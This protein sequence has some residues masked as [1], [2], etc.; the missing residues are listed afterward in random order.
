MPEVPRGDTHVLQVGAGGS[1][2]RVAETALLLRQPAT[3]V[4]MLEPAMRQRLDAAIDG[5]YVAIHADSMAQAL[6]RA[7]RDPSVRALLI[8]PCA[9]RVEQE[10]ALG[11]LALRC[12]GVMA[13]AIV[14]DRDPV[15]RERLLH[16]G[17]Q[18]VRR[19]VDV[20]ERD[21]WTRLRQL[22]GQT[23]SDT[24]TTILGQIIRTV[25]E[26]T[27]GTHAFFDVVVRL[28]PTVRS[29]KA[30][31]KTLRMQPT[32]LMSRFARAGL[33]S[34]KCYLV[35]IRLAYAA[36][37]LEPRT[38]T[39]SDVAYRLQFACPQSFGRHVRA[40]LGITAREF[41]SR[42]SLAVALDRLLDCLVI[43]FRAQLR[44]F[45]PLKPGRI[46]GRAPG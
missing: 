44:E 8:S 34:P 46:A 38:V 33:P 9:L 32:T 31:A 20:T 4:T 11:T 25:G 27:G 42:Y 30:I 16:L 41:R 26:T 13:V 3:V 36:A 6:L 15:G 29:V 21:G 35:A 45:D 5:S 28:A 19:V 17:A 43:P 1:T 40:Q 18:G 2:W 7:A 10:R 14:A 24:A 12:P 22:L 37:Y 39:V 23:G